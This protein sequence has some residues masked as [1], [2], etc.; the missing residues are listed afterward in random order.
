MVELR[1]E[2][3]W[4]YYRVKVIATILCGQ[5]TPWPALL[6]LLLVPAHKFLLR[7]GNPS[8]SS[9]GSDGT[10]LTM[11]FRYKQNLGQASESTASL[12]T[13]LLTLVMGLWGDWT[14]ESQPWN[15]CWFYREIGPFFFLLKSRS[16]L[17]VFANVRRSCLRGQPR[18][19]KK[20][21]IPNII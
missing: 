7:G 4:I 11:D 18:E 5:Y 21:Q 6:P 9:C 15:L 16:C 20:Q 17:S 13:Q 10:H 12:L 1:F 14:N 19:K 8:I 3:R 2:P